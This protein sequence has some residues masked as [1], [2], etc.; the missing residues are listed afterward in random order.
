DPLRE[1]A[2]RELMQV[3]AA[4]GNY[5]AVL[6]VYRELRLLMHRQ[7]NTEPDTETTALF[8]Q[9]RAEARSKSE[10]ARRRQMVSQALPERAS[11]RDLGSD[12]MRDLAEPERVFQP[13]HP[14]LPAPFPPLSAPATG[15]NNLPQS[16]TSFVGRGRETEEVRRLLA[17]TRLLTLTG[18]GGCGKTRLALHAATQI[19]HEFADGAWLVEL[20]P[21]AD[22]ALVSQTVVSA[23]GAGSAPSPMNALEA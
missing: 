22:P 11:L 14:D 3:L 4:G 18:P 19:L 9:L 7:M 13:L 16:L 17:T 5:A 15:S 21:L 6:Q 2:Q 1:S 12:P 8:Q 20:A 23:L 10:G